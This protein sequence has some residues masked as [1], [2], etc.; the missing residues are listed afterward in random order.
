MTQLPAGAQMP[1]VELCGGADLS[2]FQV[3]ALDAWE[4]VT[5]PCDALPF[6]LSLQCAALAPAASIHEFRSAGFASVSCAL[7]G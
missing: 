4:N 3:Q 6:C 2:L 7:W 1:R 5:L